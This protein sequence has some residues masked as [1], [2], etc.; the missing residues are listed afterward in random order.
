MEERVL[1]RIAEAPYTSTQ[2]MAYEMDLSHKFACG[3]FYTK[4]AFTIPSAK[5]TMFTKR[6]L[7]PPGRLYAED[8][9]DED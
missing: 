9:R 7:S 8:S 2:S 4:N 5:G 3:L 6:S 1:A